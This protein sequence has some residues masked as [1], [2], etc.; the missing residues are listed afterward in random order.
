[1]KKE[2][3]FLFSLF[4]NSFFI[5]L[6]KSLVVFVLNIEIILFRNFAKHITVEIMIL[7]LYHLWLALP[8]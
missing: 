4:L 2:Q 8:P 1:M 6:W 3:L 5:L 7:S